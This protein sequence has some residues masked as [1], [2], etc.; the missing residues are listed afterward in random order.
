M[1][2]LSLLLLTCG[3]SEA[4]VNCSKSLPHAK[5]STNYNE[6]IAHAIHSMT[7][8]GLALFSDRPTEKNYVPTVNQ[9]LNQP[10]LVLE[11]AP[12]D[13]LNHDFATTTMNIV[14]KILSTLGNSK[15]GLG[16]NWSPVERVAHIFHMWDLWYQIKTTQ[17][18][19]IQ[20]NPPADDVC[21][22][23]VSVD[24]NGIKVCL[25]KLIIFILSV[26]PNILT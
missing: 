10:S 9:D 25:I 22:C 1:V 13:P 18:A 2:I 5:L 3:C 14:D 8:E 24:F 19:N 12:S 26:F 17:W 21:S 7:V 20:T 15:D 6:T 23:L 11:H 4:V 16:P